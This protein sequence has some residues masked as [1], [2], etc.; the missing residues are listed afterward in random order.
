MEGGTQNLAFSLYTDLHNCIEHRDNE[1]ST[2][3]GHS[4]HSSVTGTTPAAH[5]TMN[6][7]DYD[8]CCTEFYVTMV[9]TPAAQSTTILWLQLLLHRALRYY[10]YNS[11]CTEHYDTMVTTPAVQTTMILWL[12]PCCTE[13]CDTTVNASA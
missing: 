2:E 12:Q 6:Y 11:C 8:S 7:Y 9:T 13:H 10:G 3:K 4:E 5:S 1:M